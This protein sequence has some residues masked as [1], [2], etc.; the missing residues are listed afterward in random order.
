MLSGF[1]RIKKNWFTMLELIFVCTVFAMLVSW[2]ILAINRTYVFMNNTRVQIRATN[3]TREW[4]EMMFNIR[5]TNRRKCSWEKDKFWLYLGSGVNVSEEKECKVSHEGVDYIFE[6]WIY[7]LKEWKKGDSWD[8][9]IYAER[10]T[11]IDDDTFYT[12]EWFF[13]DDEDAYIK[14]RNWAIVTF[15]WT[16]TYLSWGVPV[17]WEIG[18]LLWNW[19]DFYRIAR[20]YGIYDK[21]GGPDTEVEDFNL[22][23]ST[24][25]EM[26]FCVK[27]FYKL[28]AGEHSTELCSIMTNFME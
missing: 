3:L 26:R 15:T 28:W 12:L 23:D 21:N 25:K 2:I 16:Y 8:R 19:V 22:M 18:D 6:K 27:T 20:V 24:P 1:K 13:K 10:L 11:D 5:D 14:A 9:F 4:M 7:A 17:V